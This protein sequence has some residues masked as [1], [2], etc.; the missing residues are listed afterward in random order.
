MR[1]TLF[2]ISLVL[3]ALAVALVDDTAA[4]RS[5]FVPVSDAV[6]RSPARATGSAGGA[7]GCSTT[8]RCAP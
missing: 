2:R 3:A 4:Q 7:T 6:L 1:G 5:T 8:A